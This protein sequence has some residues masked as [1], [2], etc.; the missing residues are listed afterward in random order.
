M[1]ET[2]QHILQISLNTLNFLKAL[3]IAAK[4]MNLNHV[5]KWK[6]FLF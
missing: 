2:A 6:F 5:V 4:G 3:I 1:H